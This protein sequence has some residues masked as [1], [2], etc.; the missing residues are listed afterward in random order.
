MARN[1]VFVLLVSSFFV[2][3]CSS[4]PQGNNN[5]NSNAGAESNL[6]AEPEGE[7]LELMQKYTCVSCHKTNAKLVGPSWAEI[8]EKNYPEARMLELIRKPEPA[9]WPG[10]PPMLGIDINDADAS[11]IIQWIKSL[12]K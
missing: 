3:S 8:A 1:F 5:T 2:F 11:K 7:V 4:S 6:L 12:N 10:Y 9:N